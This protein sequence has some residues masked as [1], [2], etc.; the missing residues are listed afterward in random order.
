MMATSTHSLW[1]VW[2]NARW[3]C[4][5]FWL[6]RFEASPSWSLTVCAHVAWWAWL[7]SWRTNLKKQNK[8]TQKHQQETAWRKKS[9]QTSQRKTSSEL[10][11]SEWTLLL[12][13]SLSS[14][15]MALFLARPRGNGRLVMVGISSSEWFE[16]SSKVFSTYTVR[17]R[18]HRLE[19]DVSPSLIIQLCHAGG[20]VTQIVMIQNELI[21]PL[22]INSSDRW[23]LQN[24]IIQ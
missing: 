22:N 6:F 16:S 5:C 9:L 18:R 14:T 17:K 10:L 13:D 20:L 23:Y 19:L 24:Q 12:P 1:R 11:I 2:G 8:Q 4:R 21:S 15:A 3:A 7:E